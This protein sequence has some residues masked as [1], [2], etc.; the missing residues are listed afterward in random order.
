MRKCGEMTANDLTDF[1]ACLSVEFSPY[2]V[3]SLT[4]NGILPDDTNFPSVWLSSYLGPTDFWVVS[5]GEGKNCS[6]SYS[7]GRH[8]EHRVRKLYFN[9]T[10][11]KES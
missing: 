11:L 1:Y 9:T 6:V 4:M 2:S 7:V 3:D 5:P 8:D 10:L